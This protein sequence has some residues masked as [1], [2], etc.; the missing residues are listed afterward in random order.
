ML[1]LRHRLLTFLFLTVTSVLLAIGIPQLRIDTSFDSLISES[2]PTKA[3]Y[4]AI[5]EEFGSDNTTIIYVRDPD[6]WTEEKL[7]ALEKLSFA[8]EDLPFV[9]KVESLFNVR[10]IRDR[11]GDI[12]SSVVLDGVPVDAAGVEQARANALYSPLVTR[13]FISTDGTVTALNVNVRKDAASPDFD[14]QAFE[15]INAAIDPVRSTFTEIYQVGPPRVN[16]DLKTSLYGDMKVLGPL[17]LGVLMATIVIFL[18]SGMAAAVPLCTALLSLVWTFG[19]MGFAGVPVNVLSAMLP[20]LVI[21]IGSTEDTHMLATYLTGLAEGKRG[22]S[23]PE[24]RRLAVIFMAKHMGLPV[25]LTTTTTVLGFASNGVSEIA[26]IRD[27]AFASTAGIAFN[28][29]ITVLAVP[30]ILSF[31]GPL[32][33]KLLGTGE[34]KVPAASE[35]SGADGHAAPSGMVRGVIAMCEWACGHPNSVIAG[36]VVMVGL[37]GYFSTQ[38]TVSN[39]PISYFRQDH[40]LVQDVEKLHRDL[41][42]MELFYINL[43]SSQPMA[44]KD[45]QNLRKLAEIKAFIMS[46][47]KFDNAIS[48]ADHL[49]LVNR[50][51]HGGDPAGMTVPATAD[52]VEQYLLFFQRSDLDSY[53]SHDFQRVNMVVR[54]NIHN[55]HE[56]TL[57]L[58]DLERK[59]AE[60]SGG[61]VQHFLVGQNLMINRAAEALMV[62]Q[63][64]SIGLLLVVIFV[65]M[66]LVYTSLIGGVL[67]LIPNIV[68]IVMTFGLMGLFNIPINPG[69]ATVAVIAIGIAI[70]DTIHLLSFYA[71]ES[72]RTP[73]RQQAVRITIRHEAIPVVSTTVAL[74]AGFLVLVASNFSIV[75]QF[76]MLSALAMA[77]ALIADLII[78]PVLMAKVRLVSVYEILLLKVGRDVLAKSPLFE[79]MSSYQARKAILLSQMTEFRAGTRLIRQ[80]SVGREMFLILSGDVAVTL[81]RDGEE[82]RLATLSAG[83][84]FG[85]AGFVSD[86][87]RSANVDAL[88]DGV[89]LTFEFERVR[90]NMWLYPHIASRLNLNIA[91]ILGERLAETSTHLAGVRQGEAA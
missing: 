19:L 13:N 40:A 37:F 81:D 86:Q 10:S 35:K 26:L 5:K 47:G 78:T 12:E 61:T 27:F 59:V 91:R 32:P 41:S 75:A 31:A 50:E 76:G 2:D 9:E 90:R 62:A 45:P 85:E 71:A 17:S 83:A 73:D 20:S 84:V 48:L 52:L 28:G 39:D 34:G 67:S 24:T 33:K 66:S 1:G 88:S 87:K 43:Q 57:A 72:R 55:S 69:T 29:L 63:L 49:S 15:A 30:L 74:I 23:R 6:L 14:R 80:G 22:L 53:V 44:F 65:M 89:M 54:H 42:G 58:A 77:F 16:E 70:D 11:N 8:L 7:L 82:T 21:V 51:F 4:E 64:Q 36:T 79:G 18:R 38:I 3:A 25:L 60:I 56:L 68:P 46:E